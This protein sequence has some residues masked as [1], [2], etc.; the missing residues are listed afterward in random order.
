MV[1]RE[2]TI[3]VILRKSRSLSAQKR[4]AYKSFSIIVISFYNLQQMFKQKTSFIFFKKSNQYIVLV[5]N[6]K[7]NPYK[8]IEVTKMTVHNP[9]AKHQ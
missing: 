8:I 5:L 9:E 2:I 3:V 1:E 4:L 6:K 7:Y